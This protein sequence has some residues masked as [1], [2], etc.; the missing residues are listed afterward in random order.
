MLYQT[1]YYKIKR[2]HFWCCFSHELIVP[3]T[4]S[5]VLI[6]WYS[7]NWAVF[8]KIRLMVYKMSHEKIKIFYFRGT[9]PIFSMEQ[10]V[11]IF[12]S[13]SYHTPLLYFYAD[14]AELLEND[15][16]IFVCRSCFSAWSYCLPL[17][18][19]I[20]IFQCLIN[21]AFR[22]LKYFIFVQYSRFSAKA[23]CLKLF[24][25]NAS[26]IFQCLIPTERFKHEKVLILDC[27]LHS[28]INCSEYFLMRS[29][30]IT[31][32]YELRCIWTS[33]WFT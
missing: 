15:N 31:M 29:I 2:F 5:S 17:I 4:S 19:S 26:T 12:E 9:V 1:S 28:W 23:N 20:I 13:H 21:W 7:N 24:L 22:K 8:E 14:L 32:L 11:S 3:K 16:V 27:S 30:D 10:K 33:K 6:F 18:D 25:R